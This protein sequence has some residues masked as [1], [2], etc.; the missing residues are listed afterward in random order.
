VNWTPIWGG[1]GY[2]ATVFSTAIEFTVLPGELDTNMGRG[3][4]LSEINRG[5]SIQ[6]NFI[7]SLCK[8]R[9]AIQTFTTNRQ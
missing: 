1:G 4:L 5:N 3:R 9:V 6:N 7:L 8:Y 2:W